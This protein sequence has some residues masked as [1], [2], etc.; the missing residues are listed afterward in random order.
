MELHVVCK[1]VVVVL[2]TE[3]RSVSCE[4]FYE[5][6]AKHIDRLPAYVRLRLCSIEFILLGGQSIP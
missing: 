6:S 1:D 4:R 5:E 3:Q 2:S